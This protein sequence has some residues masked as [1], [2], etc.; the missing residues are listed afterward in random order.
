MRKAKRERMEEGYAEGT[1]QDKAEGEKAKTLREIAK[2]LKAKGMPPLPLSHAS[3]YSPP[4]FFL[5]GGTLRYRHT[6]FSL[7]LK[8]SL[9]S[10]YFVAP[11]SD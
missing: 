11:P 5:A 8:I 10:Y 3:H 2:S 9:T 7:L 4:P 6:P 1:Q